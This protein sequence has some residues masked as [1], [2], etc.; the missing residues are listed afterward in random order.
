[1]GHQHV[2]VLLSIQLGEISPFFFLL[3]VKDAN[4]LCN[5]MKFNP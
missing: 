4:C 5:Y 2:V 1:M 3:T